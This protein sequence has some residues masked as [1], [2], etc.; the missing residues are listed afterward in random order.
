MSYCCH[1]CFHKMAGGFLDRMILCPTCGNKRCP[2]A[3][4]H[5]L[6]CTGSNEPNQPG[7]IYGGRPVEPAPDPDTPSSNLGDAW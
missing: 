4:D 7:S 3:T 2:K 5:D 6:D 1:T